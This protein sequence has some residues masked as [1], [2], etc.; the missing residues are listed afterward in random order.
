MLSLILLATACSTDEDVPSL[1]GIVA[2]GLQKAKADAAAELGVDLTCA[3]VDAHNGLVAEA[4]GHRATIKHYQNIIAAQEKA[5]AECDRYLAYAEQSCSN[6]GT[7]IRN[8]TPM[9]RRFGTASSHTFR[10]ACVSAG[11]S[12]DL[13]KEFQAPEGFKGSARRIA[14][15]VP[16]AKS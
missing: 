14:L 12:G 7:F 11:I 15:A 3:Y 8:I 6:T 1:P 5:L 16:K 4:A 2:D 9:S 13:P 10:T